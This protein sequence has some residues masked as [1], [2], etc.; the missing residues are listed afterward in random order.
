[1]SSFG[2]SHNMII[3]G[4][5]ESGVID[6]F[7]Y[8]QG[9]NSELLAVDTDLEGAERLTPDTN[10]DVGAIN[11]VATGTEINTRQGRK[12][13]IM[14]IH[15]SGIVYPGVASTFRNLIRIA[16]V[17]DK[18][19]TGALPTIIDLFGNTTGSLISPYGFINPKNRERFE[20]LSIVRIA[21]GSRVTVAPIY[22]EAPT[23]MGYDVFLDLSM[24]KDIFT[25]FSGTTATIASISYGAIYVCTVGTQVIANTHYNDS[26]S[27]VT[28]IDT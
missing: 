24:R 27:R 18:Q 22:V 25:I 4:V 8:F 23:V 1:M 2:Q 5:P 17:F 10:G 19:P 6:E 15:H 13:K 16:I 20:V 28:Y 14:S 7:A 26:Y 12:I 21:L 9:L 3:I 11:L